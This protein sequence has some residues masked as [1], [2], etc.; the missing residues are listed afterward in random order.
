MKDRSK[1][2]AQAEAWLG[3]KRGD[4]KY[5]EML[6]WFNKNP[7]GLKADTEN[8][9]EFTVACAIK[10]FG[11]DEKYI[12]VCNYANGQA[13]MWKKLTTAPSV[14][15]LAYFDYQ[16]GNGISHVEI[17]TDVTPTEVKTI[18]GNSNH[19]VVRV[20]RKRTYKYFAGFGLPDWPK[21]EV[22]MTKWQEAA[23]RQI[24]LKKGS[25]GTLVRWLQMYLQEQGFYKNGTL[26]GIFG[27]YMQQAVK[28]FQRASAGKP[29]GDLYVDGIV[30]WNTWNYIL[31]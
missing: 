25:V 30:G 20:T 27:S 15:S 31:K 21:E 24:V 8:C 2:I 17:V 11:V 7:K 23:A 4:G 5:E 16:D 9:C 3:A 28:D 18:N 10:A 1:Y 6:E 12:P 19:K 29:K 22:D 14:G 26:D 13:K